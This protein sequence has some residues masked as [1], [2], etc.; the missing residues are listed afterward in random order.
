[1]AIEESVWMELCRPRATQRCSW[2]VHNFTRF[3]INCYFENFI[4]EY[5]GDLSRAIRSLNATRFGVYHS[6][7]E[8]F[9]PLWMQDKQANLTTRYFVTE[10]VLPE[11]YELVK[12]VHKE[13]N[14]DPIINIIYKQYSLVIGA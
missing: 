9:N 2:S 3:Y 7:Y 8:W 14:K 12:Y 13:N 6:L 11:L 1:M 10:K 4:Y 5:L